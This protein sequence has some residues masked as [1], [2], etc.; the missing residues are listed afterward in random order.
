M[1][2]M[3]DT[4]D[5]VQLACLLLGDKVPCRM[6]WPRHADLKINMSSYSPYGRN[7]NSKLGMNAVDEAFNMSPYLKEG[8]NLVVGLIC[9]PCH[10]HIG[11]VEF[12][13][14]G[15]DESSRVHFRSTT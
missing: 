11:N 14:D 8:S 3:A 12:A 7:K 2:A 6:N 13:C 10:Q 9:L 5:I 4:W 15:R 1:K